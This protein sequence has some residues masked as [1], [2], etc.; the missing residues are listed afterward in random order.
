MTAP[1][2]DPAGVVR[3]RRQLIADGMTD[4]QIATLVR[5]KV[6]KRVRY[7]AFV[8]HA[9]WDA[10]DPEDRHRVLARAVLAT[11]HTST[12]LTHASSIIERRIP[13][14]GFPLDVV[15]TTRI[16]PERA[17]RRKADWVPH[18]GLLRED[19]L[20]ELNG[21]IVSSAAR[22]AFEL[23]T[24]SDV[25]RSLVA[26]NRLLH[27]GAMTVGELAEQ[28]ECHQRWPGSLTSD[29]VLRLA[30]HRLESVG[31]DRFSFL[32]YKHGLPRP[33]P[34]VEI[35][36]EHG[37]SV[38]RVDFAWP[39]LGVFV[40]FDGR[41]KYARYRRDGETL[42]EFLMREKAREELV[43]LLTGW[44]CIR[45]SWADLAAPGKLATRIRA[46]IAARNTVAL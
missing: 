43:C 6:L 38:A 5:A 14:W 11:A 26:V 23:T 19:D 39:D 25:E 12:A 44:T 2:F 34:Q 24:I 17:G 18:R 28:V 32:A 29:L 8:D 3:L 16:A 35:F 22:A 41:A 37:L 20:E 7:G 15:H 42:E 46:V 13:L 36:D 45:V 9:V 33:E 10:L 27:A 31:E 40:E 30:D 1:S 21:V 4:T